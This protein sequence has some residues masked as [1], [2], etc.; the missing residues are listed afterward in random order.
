MNDLYGTLPNVIKGWGIINR[1]RTHFRV[2]D[3][4]GTPRVFPTRKEASGYVW[5]RDVIVRVKV[6]TEVVEKKHAK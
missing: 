3:H 6:T 1:N 2:Q 5:D 4:D